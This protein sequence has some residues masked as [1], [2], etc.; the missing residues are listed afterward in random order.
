MLQ[1]GGTTH[2]KYCSFSE[3]KYCSFSD[4]TKKILSS[5]HYLNIRSA[6]DEENDKEK[7]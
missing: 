4:N 6:K 7:R 2:R 5:S 3:I 1:E